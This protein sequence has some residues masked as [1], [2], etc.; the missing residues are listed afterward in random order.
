MSGRAMRKH[1]SKPL[2]N[3]VQS[4]QT[5]YLVQKI[6]N[7]E[8]VWNWDGDRFKVVCGKDERIREIVLESLRKKEKRG[9]IQL[10][11]IWSSGMTSERVYV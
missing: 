4:K 6:A 11:K 7:P 8:T 1:P 5:R 2:A 10:P 9:Q 3:L